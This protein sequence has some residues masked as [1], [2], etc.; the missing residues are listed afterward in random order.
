MMDEFFERAGGFGAGANAGG[1]E[2]M[3]DSIGRKVVRR[4]IPQTP[5]RR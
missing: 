4:V 2:G 3:T 1:A 5:S